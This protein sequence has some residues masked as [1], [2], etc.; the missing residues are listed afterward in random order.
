MKKIDLIIQPIIRYQN[1]KKG[2]L[3][4]NQID[5]T[6]N[7]QT[8]DNVQD[9]DEALS[10]NIFLISPEP[11]RN[12]KIGD[13]FVTVPEYDD[14][15]E[16]T[17]ITKEKVSGK[18]VINISNDKYETNENVHE[19]KI[20]N[21]RKVI[22]SGDECPFHVPQLS[23][24]SINEIVQNYND[25]NEGI[26]H[27]TFNVDDDD[28]NPEVNEENKIDLIKKTEEEKVVEIEG[29]KFWEQHIKPELDKINCC[30][31]IKILAA[32]LQEYKNHLN[33]IK[34]ESNDKKNI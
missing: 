25:S 19:F 31:N 15:F 5:G 8:T 23:D 33:L 12:I 26:Y 7:F 6:I 16:C 24:E 28:I 13:I 22:A 27:L 29:L 34:K 9:S 11:G 4:I 1:N 21:T 30:G 20:Y 2:K 32:F 17:S 10:T 3:K 18:N 14:F